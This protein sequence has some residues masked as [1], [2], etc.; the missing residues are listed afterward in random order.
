MLYRMNPRGHWSAWMGPRG[1][2][3]LRSRFLGGTQVGNFRIRKTNIYMIWKLTRDMT[4]RISWAAAASS[5]FV[6]WGR[7][8]SWDDRP[9]GERAI[10]WEARLASRLP[11]SAQWHCPPLLPT[12]QLQGAFP[13]STSVLMRS[14]VGMHRPGPATGPGP[15]DQEGC[16][17]AGEHS[18][19]DLLSETFPEP[20]CLIL[21]C[22]H[23]NTFGGLPG[24]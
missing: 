11:E 16:P 13:S 6:S 19:P 3:P 18:L 15:W 17:R 21:S 2:E 12:P 10:I 23:C 5:W 8:E 4:V 1:R 22:P 7:A 24:S 9:G 20:H 14:E